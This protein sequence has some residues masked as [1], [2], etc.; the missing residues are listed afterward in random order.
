MSQEA[1]F[2]LV[3][4]HGYFTIFILMAFG[5]VGLPIPDELLMTY[6]GYLVSEGKL[7]YVITVVVGF[8]GSICGMSFNF[9]LGRWFGLNLLEKHRWK[10]YIKAERLNRAEQWFMKFGRLTVLFGYFIPGIRNLTALLAGIGEWNYRT[11]AFYAYPGGFIWVLTFVTLGFLLQKRW[12][13][14]SIFLQQ[15]VWVIWLVFSI[16]ILYWT[17]QRW[18]KSKKRA[19]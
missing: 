8:L 9:F 6:A 4:Q 11:F 12:N 7:Q 13:Y 19:R 1:I 16:A 2:Q 14:I 3:S 17:I 10:I 15:Y 18:I 5:I